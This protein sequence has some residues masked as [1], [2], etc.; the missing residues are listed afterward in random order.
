MAAT[1]NH[2]GLRPRP[3]RHRHAPR[4]NPAKPRSTPG[5][6]DTK[7]SWCGALRQPIPI[8]ACRRPE[9]E[10]VLTA[11]RQI[12][13][14]QAMDRSHGLA[15]LSRSLGLSPPPFRPRTAETVK[16]IAMATQPR[17][18]ISS[19][20]SSTAPQCSLLQKSRQHTRSGCRLHLDLIGLP[21][22]RPRSMLPRRTSLPDAY[23]NRSTACSPARTTAALC[24]HGLVVARYADSNGYQRSTIRLQPPLDTITI[25]ASTVHQ[26]LTL[27]PLH[28]SRQNSGGMNYPRPRPRQIAAPG[29]SLQTP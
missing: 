27:L 18:T 29:V 12:P 3:S 2:S 10:H 19:G 23:E 14:L 5:H 9:S 17:S 28:P 15:L 8:S 22:A 20:P 11:A 26:D 6:P 13:N 25:T 1:S 4:Q 21:N 24:P 16:E 7:A